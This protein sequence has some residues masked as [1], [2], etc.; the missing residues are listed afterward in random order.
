[1]AKNH[2]IFYNLKCNNISQTKTLIHFKIGCCYIPGLLLTVCHGSKLLLSIS[3]VF[4]PQQIGDS[5]MA[6]FWTFLGFLAQSAE[7]VSPPKSSSGHVDRSYLDHGILFLVGTTTR[8]EILPQK[9]LLQ[10]SIAKMPETVANGFVP[11]VDGGILLRSSQNVA[12]AILP[13]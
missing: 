3:E 1:M 8:V 5:K 4:F 6:S 10:C 12:V 9:C 13:S 2:D 11:R 7:E